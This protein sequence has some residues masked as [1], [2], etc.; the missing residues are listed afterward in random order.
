[1]LSKALSPPLR[2]QLQDI[3]NQNVRS[4]LGDQEFHLSVI[5]LN[6]GEDERSLSFGRKTSFEFD[7]EKSRYY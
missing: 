1:M 4:L 6:D 3:Y 5:S 7:D 2:A